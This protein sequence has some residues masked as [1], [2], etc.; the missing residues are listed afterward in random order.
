MGQLELPVFQRDRECK[1]C[2][3]HQYA[4][5]VC[6]PTRHY[7]LSLLPPAPLLIFIGQNP[8]ANEDFKDRSFVGDSGN[9][10]EDIYIQPLD[11]HR[12]CTIFLTNA[13]R[14]GPTNDIRPS[15]TRKCFPLYT[16]SDLEQLV[17]SVAPDTRAC[18]CLLGGVAAHALSFQYT[19]AGRT[20]TEAIR[21]NGNPLTIANRTIPIFA[22][23][24]PAALLR[25]NNLI[26]EVASHMQLVRDYFDGIMAVPSSPHIIPPRYPHT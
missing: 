23:W 6:I 3:L 4:S 9:Y 15:Q 22:T 13:A 7:E 11:F 8:G 17:N 14:C 21:A 24:H 10:L 20:A 18:V 5:N 25:D 1:A 2:P 19:G 16:V 12:T 26:H